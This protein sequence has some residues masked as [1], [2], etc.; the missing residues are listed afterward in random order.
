MEWAYE[1]CSAIASGDARVRNLVSKTRTIVVPVVNLD[2][3]NASREAGE[4]YS[5]GGGHDTDYDGNGEIDDPEFILAGSTHPNEYR[6]KNCRFLGDPAA[7]ATAPRV[8]Q[9]RGGPRRRPEP[10]LRRLLGRRR[11]EWHS[12]HADLPRPGP[13]LG[14]GD[15]ERARADLGAPGH[16]ADHEPHVLEPRAAPARH[17]R[18]GRRR[19]T[20][21]S[22][23]R[24]ATRWRPRTATRASTGTS[25]TTPTG[26]PR[27]GPTTPPAVSASRSRSAT[28]ASTR[29]SRRRWR[30][31]TARRTTRP[32]AA[33]ARPTT[34]PSRTPPTRAS[35][36][37]SPGVHPPGRSCV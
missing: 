15:A 14:A 5:N 10:Q 6:R 35:T 19:S 16:D 37:C 29:R 13:V 31:G 22:T 34:R 3:F 30:S 36:R 7:R 26:P 32:A 12:A 33:T 8:G 9:R 17:R 20:S 27:T 18:A 28:S 21:R 1:L 24:S 11:L 2:G 4:L 25:C 23:R